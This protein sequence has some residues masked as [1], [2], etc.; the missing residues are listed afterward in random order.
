LLRG[1]DGSIA[2]VIFRTDS[3]VIRDVVQF[4]GYTGVLPNNGEME[5]SIFSYLTYPTLLTEGLG[6]KNLVNRG[7]RQTTTRTEEGYMLTSQ[8]G[9]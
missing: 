3:S 9:E 4:R 7:A 2:R 8:E 1:N 5:T 6:F